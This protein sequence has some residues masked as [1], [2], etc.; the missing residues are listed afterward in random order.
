MTL[1]SI[2]AA[3]P[4]VIKKRITIRAPS[5][6]VATLVGFESIDPLS[7]DGIIKEKKR[8][9]AANGVFLEAQDAQSKCLAVFDD[10]VPKLLLMH[11]A[12]I[13]SAICQPTTVNPSV[14]AHRHP[15]WVM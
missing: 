6:M 15:P 11:G 5:L 3:E 14:A 7:G 4:V 8:L 13:A 2:G 9:G 12:T 1:V 10:D